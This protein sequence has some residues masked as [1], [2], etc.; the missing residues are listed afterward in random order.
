[1]EFVSVVEHAE[2]SPFN[3]KKNRKKIIDQF[4]HVFHKVKKIFIIFT[5]FSPKLTKELLSDACFNKIQS[6]LYNL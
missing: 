6:I 5:L 1:M 2:S 4:F 3:K